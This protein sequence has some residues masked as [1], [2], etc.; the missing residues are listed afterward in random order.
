MWIV[1]NIGP[2]GSRVDLCK[3]DQRYMLEENI[4]YEEAQTAYKIA[5]E[6]MYNI[7]S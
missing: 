4:S 7:T 5:S 2:W 6:L 3:I 1:R